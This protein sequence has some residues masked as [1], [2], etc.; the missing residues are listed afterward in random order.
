MQESNEGGAGNKKFGHN[1]YK[2][3]MYS[4]NTVNHIIAT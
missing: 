2:L 1:S 4:M 3:Y